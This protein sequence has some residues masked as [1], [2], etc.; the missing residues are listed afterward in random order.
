MKKFVQSFKE[1]T[2]CDLC[3]KEGHDKSP[4]RRYSFYD[5]HDKCVYA[6]IKEN[7]IQEEKVNLNIS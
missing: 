2:L 1:I 7:K 3:G 6:L 5:V 4:M